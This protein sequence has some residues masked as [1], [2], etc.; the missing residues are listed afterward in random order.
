M[1]IYTALPREQYQELIAVHLLFIP[2]SFPRLMRRWSYTQWRY[3]H[4]TTDASYV[5]YKRLFRTGEA[6]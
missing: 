3:M 6:V 4:V 2:S 1:M 5:G